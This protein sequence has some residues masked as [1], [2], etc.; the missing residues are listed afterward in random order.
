M[1]AR[2][3]CFLVVFVFSLSAVAGSEPYAIPASSSDFTGIWRLLPLDPSADPKALKEDLWPATC[4]YF[5]HY[6]GGNWFHQQTH[7]G[8]CN[9]QIPD[10]P[11]KFPVNVTW[12]MPQLGLVVID[13]P[14]YKIKE[15]WKVDKIT[16]DAHLGSTNLNKGDLI[17][18]MIGKDKRYI[19]VRLL[20]RVK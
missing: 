14:D 13:R 19:Y 8:A 16:G 9:N 6:S 2:L 10:L 5:G 15:V 17:M 4:Q 11:Y 18:Q 12:K 7:L 3:G 1:I 20:R